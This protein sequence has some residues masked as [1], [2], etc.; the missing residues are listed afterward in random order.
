MTILESLFNEPIALSEKG[1]LQLEKDYQRLSQIDVDVEEE[2]YSSSYE[3]KPIEELH[4]NPDT[5]IGVIEVSGYLVN[6]WEWWLKYVDATSYEQILADMQ[7]MLEAGAHTIIQHNVSGGG[8]AYGVFEAA[9]SMR[10]MLDEYEAEMITYSDGITASAAFALAAPSNKIIVNPDSEIGSVGVVVA[11]LDTSEYMK[12]EGLKR[13]YIT[14]GKN[15][16]PFDKDGKFTKE[17]LAD[18]QEGVDKTYDKFTSHIS[19]YRPVTKESLVDVGAKV[20][21]AEDAVAFGYADEV[22]SSND[23]AEYLAD[24]VTRKGNSMSFLNTLIKPKKESTMSVDTPNPAVEGEV[25]ETL[26]TVKLSYEAKLAEMKDIEAGLQASI[27]EFETKLAE[28]NAQVE[29]LTQSLATLE[30]EKANAK[31]ASR[32]AKLTK[33]VGDVKG[34]ELAELYASFSDEQFA[35]AL[36]AISGAQD[37]NAETIE[38]EIGEEGAVVVPEVK[39]STTQAMAVQLAEKYKNTVV[40]PFQ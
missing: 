15:K 9:T 31:A 33:V 3:P 21:D 25:Q 30:S 17:F 19:T 39:M 8:Q 32:L 14:A 35:T 1:L 22:M 7:T 27:A 24:V 37:S 34:A 4:Y 2:M 5:G 16:V 40:N 29:A 6:K 38:Q 28:A 18:L 36:A 26:E 23:F 13:I 20:F 10:A 11:L 12:K